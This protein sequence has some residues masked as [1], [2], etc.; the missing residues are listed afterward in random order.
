MKWN[1]LSELI[2]KPFDTG[3]GAADASRTNRRRLVSDWRV[4]PVRL[5]WILP[6]IALLII[7]YRAPSSARK[8]I[9]APALL[10]FWQTKKK[11]KKPHTIRFSFA[12]NIRSTIISVQ[13][14]VNRFQV[15]ARALRLRFSLPIREL[16]KSEGRKKPSRIAHGSR[17]LITLINW[18]TF[19]AVFRMNWENGRHRQPPA[20]TSE[21]NGNANKQRKNSIS[22]INSKAMSRIYVYGSLHKLIR[23]ICCT[24]THTHTH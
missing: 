13:N 17:K 9:V 22:T 7:S 3:S 4:R 14:R 15:L 1:L 16:V 5:D 6:Y 19:D 12:R 8:Q 23:W 10:C 18:T 21:Q 20:K 11:K 2:L 24:H